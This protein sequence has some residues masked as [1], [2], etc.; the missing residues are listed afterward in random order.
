M[1]DGDVNGLLAL[2]QNGYPFSDY[3]ARQLLY[4]IRLRRELDYEVCYWMLRSAMARGDT[5]CCR[6]YLADWTHSFSRPGVTISRFSPG[7]HWHVLGQR[8]GSYADAEQYAK[9]RGYRIVGEQV[10]EARRDGD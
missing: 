9:S 1:D 2:S 3:A 4:G 5:A 10:V 6:Q 8:F 7:V